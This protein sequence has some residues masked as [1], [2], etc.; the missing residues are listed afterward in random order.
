[1]RLN[2]GTKSLSHWGSAELPLWV[3]LHCSQGES[4]IHMSSLFF[5]LFFICFTDDPVVT[6]VVPR[7]GQSHC[8]LGNKA[9]SKLKEFDDFPPVVTFAIALCMCVGGCMGDYV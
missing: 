7:S 1:M 3:C 9:A 2:S 4:H 5:H 6:E 8:Y